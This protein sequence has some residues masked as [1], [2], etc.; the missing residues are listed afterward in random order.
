MRSFVRALPS[1]LSRPLPEALARL[2]PAADGRAGRSEEGRVGPG[3]ERTIRRLADLASL[4]ERRSPTGKCLRRSLLRYHYL[5]RAGVPLELRFG[6]RTDA[7]P[8]DDPERRLTAHA[9]VT[10]D[11]R[12]YHEPAANVEGYVVVLAWPPPA[13]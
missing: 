10:L 9:W 13:A 5:R 8:A 11:G 7:A 1:E 3:A 4:L 6:A 12:P 2:T